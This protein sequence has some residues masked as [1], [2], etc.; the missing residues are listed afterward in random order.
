MMYG[1]SGYI[2]LSLIQVSNQ[3]SN[4]TADNR[5][6]SRSDSWFFIS[7]ELISNKVELYWTT[8]YYKQKL[9]IEK[10]PVGMIYDSVMLLTNLRNFMYPNMD[11]KCF[12]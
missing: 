1:D 6:F 10:A 11:F 4:L 3:G 12:Q 2:N 9:R 7:F 5:A 8:L